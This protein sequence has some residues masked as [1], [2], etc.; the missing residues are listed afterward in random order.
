MAD[1]TE[2]VAPVHIYWNGAL[3]PKARFPNEGWMRNG[4]Y[5]SSQLTPDAET[6]WPAQGAIGAELIFRTSM[7]TYHATTVMALDQ[8]VAT[9]SPAL[10]FPAGQ[11]QNNRWGF[12]IQGTEQLVDEVGEWYYD[13]ANQRVVL[14]TGAG[15]AP[16]DVRASYL[17]FGV[18]LPGAGS[19]NHQIVIQGIEFR[20]QREA[21]VVLRGAGNGAHG[22]A[23]SDCIFR[24]VYVGVQDRKVGAP[25][26]GGC[27][28]VANTFVDCYNMA[29]VIPDKAGTVVQ[30]N[31]LE[32]IGMIPGLGQS[33]FGGYIGMSLGGS[34]FLIEENTLDQIG[35]GG[36][37]LSGAGTVHKN[38][39]RQTSL[40]LTDGGG[41]QFD[42]S[43][44]L[45]IE[46]NV[47]LDLGGPSSLVSAAPD[48]HA[49]K[50]L[51]NGIY[52]GDKY[53]K[54]TTVRR[55]T[56]AGCFQGIYV[57]HSKCSENAVLEENTLFDNELQLVI[58]DYSNYR[59]QAGCPG[60]GNPNPFHPCGVTQEHFNLKAAYTDSYR[61]NI[62]YSLQPDQLSI[63]QAHVW[64]RNYGQMV[65]FGDFTGHYAHNPFSKAIFRDQTFYCVPDVST[66]LT[67]ESHGIPYSN[68]GWTTGVLRLE[69]ESDLSTSPL[70]Q[71]RYPSA[72]IT[73][74]T[75]GIAPFCFNCPSGGQGAWSTPSTS[76]IDPDGT[77][78]LRFTN[79]NWIEMFNES[80][81][82][83]LIVAGG[84]P[85]PAGEV[86]PGIY[87]YTLKIR[88]TGTEAIQVGPYWTG[89]NYAGPIEQIPITAEWA[90]HVLY[91]NIEDKSSTDRMVTALQ[92]VQRSLGAFT[93]TSIIDIASI[94]VDRVLIDELAYKSW[95]EDQH[96]LFYYANLPGTEDDERNV[97]STS[98]MVT[99]PGTTGC[100]S[101]VFGNFYAAG[102]QIP[103]DEW[104]SIILFRMDVPDA[105]LALNG[106]GEH[107]ITANTLWTDNMNVEGSVVV[108]DGF[109]LTIDGAHIGFAASTQSLT[110][111]ITVQPGGTLVLRN[112]ATLRNWMGCGSA[113]EMWDGV[114]V[115][116][117]GTHTGAGMVVME[118]GARIAN[119]HIAVVTADVN[120]AG[121]F[122]TAANA[123]G[124]I[125]ASN[126]SFVN[127]RHDVVGCGLTGFDPL[128]WGPVSFT[129]CSFLR[130]EQL[131]IESGQPGYRCILA[132]HSPVSFDRC[133]FRCDATARDGVH[134]ENSILSM[135]SRVRVTGDEDTGE[136]SKFKGF[137]W[138]MVMSAFD[139]TV[140]AVVDRCD[141]DGN[142]FGLL[143]AGADN[144]IV[145]NSSFIVADAETNADLGVDAAYGAYLYG[146]SGFE[147]EE[148]SFAGSGAAHP[149]VGLVVRNTGV[150]DNMFYNNSFSGFR[151]DSER[152][153]GTIIMGANATANFGVGL[154]IKCND[155][156]PDATNNYD[157]AFT[158]NAV[159]IADQQGS[160]V[161]DET[162]A[163][164][165]FAVVDPLTC[166]G[167]EA[168]HLYEDVELAL[169]AF[170]YYHHLPQPGVELVPHC[171]N[172]NVFLPLPTEPYSKAS[173]C[174]VDLSGLIPIGDDESTAGGAHAEHDVLVAVYDNWKDGGNTDGLIDFIK[175]P[176]NSSYAVRNQL[177]LVAPKVSYAAWKECFFRTPAMNP[178]HLAQALLANSPLE[179][180]T[181]TLLQQS[182]IDPFYKELVED[183]Q[184]GGQSMHSIYK[185]EIAHFHGVKS[186][187]LQ[188]AVRKSL[189]GDGNGDVSLTLR[190]LEDYPITG[191]EQGRFALLL[192]TNELGTA[193]N[194]VDE[195]LLAAEEDQELWQL[196]DLLLGLREQSQAP[197]ALDGNGVGQLQSI[198]ANGGMGAAQAEAWLALLGTPTTEVVLLPNRNKRLKP[199]RE[200]KRSTAR[201]LLGAYPN[202]SNGPVYLTYTVLD[203]VENV[204][205]QV[206][207]AQGRLL[208]RQRVGNTTG[209]AE[210]HPR[211]LSTG[212]HVASLYFDG[213]RVGS[214]K[215]NLVK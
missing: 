59:A 177:M 211:E 34:G 45:V 158:G 104:A 26:P 186:G 99:V 173:S 120:I 166:N 33:G 87:R 145:T 1:W 27:T 15:S 83:P 84:D 67:S 190:A 204:E 79:Q 124:I 44:G 49:Y 191:G 119:A 212:V 161:S 180:A 195:R 3:Q 108:N 30:G 198:A 37:A 14:N 187:A 48:Y 77:T 91:F 151:D 131:P 134:Q 156:D 38:H 29:L 78:Y 52:F 143:L 135:N 215:L 202:P 117:N 96:R 69:G 65:D 127:N 60:D 64:P 39:I 149:K 192:A 58:T 50:Q 70:Q 107:H 115:L 24:E 98:G 53:I 75:L 23:V 205:L 206:H 181:L 10:A 137:D 18:E 163:G 89:G 160:P 141:F 213:I 11:G 73:N 112:G 8:G 130:T 155:Y 164:N 209:I 71:A 116:G 63:V 95:M 41:I 178:W 125:Q 85:I 201:P 54:N 121:P 136:R 76:G 203:G 170:S 36:I 122:A 6:P 82:M 132:Q 171:N 179:P 90:E 196:Y 100:W 208:K 56:V 182:T 13:V 28:L 140:L 207:D 111:N 4:T 22:V 94:C 194:V 57:D 5:S 144:C 214:T 21:A 183:G 20:H 88:G 25:T 172:V 113:P 148:N 2:T 175:D 138:A 80:T 12:F 126:A 93:G 142:A 103:L 184:N 55:N 162:H 61:G 123:G 46:D 7:F 152:S 101:D 153:A 72:A 189:I 174:P 31:R 210:L 102:D 35:Y 81:T 169:N 105:N 150:A 157:V 199:Q 74:H 86:R 193:R 42:F 19:G 200:P 176:G 114:K 97:A 17:D 147:V 47:I 168:R 146:C 9:V 68:A 66:Y 139:P 51:N 43:D 185:S 106:N 154:R 109:T 110:T 118:S 92:N 129:H 128:A 197:T 62:L 167:N 159:S 32:R 40:T 165:T 16:E 133:T 188:A